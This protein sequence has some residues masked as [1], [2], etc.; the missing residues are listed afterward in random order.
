[1]FNQ[2]KWF[3]FESKWVEPNTKH[4]EASQEPPPMR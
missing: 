1:M 4:R 2:M 3:Y